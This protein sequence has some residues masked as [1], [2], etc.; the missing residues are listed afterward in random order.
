MSRLRSFGIAGFRSLKSVKVEEFGP[1]T[2]LIGPNGAGKSNLLSAMRL[3]PMLAS[4]SLGRYIL[5]R[6]GADA[7]LHYGLDTT[8][9]LAIAVEFDGPLRYEASL[10]FAAPDRLFFAHEACSDG[11]AGS[12]AG[13]PGFE[14][15]LGGSTAAVARRVVNE[16]RH[17]N[18][19]HFHDTSDRSALRTHAQL[20][21]AAYLKSEGSNLASYLWALRNGGDETLPAWNRILGWVRSI[22]PFIHDLVPDGPAAGAQ[23]MLLTWRD[24]RGK[25][26]GPDALSDGTLRAIALFTA[27]GQPATK[28]PW[29]IT[30]DE[31]ELGLHPAALSL[32]VEVMQS[33]PDTCQ[34]VVGTQSTAFLDAVEPEDVLVCDRV[35]GASEFRR[36]SRQELSVWL[37][38]EYSLARLYD[39]N[40][41][42]GRP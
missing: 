27:L 36:L 18:Y 38:D 30:I 14:S 4:G 25:V 10:E 21:D 6:G 22:A 3:I 11:G 16:F 20:A 42:G 15:S 8:K 17:W 28:L 23:S 37:D 24:E 26:F 9:A 31:P 32:L 12:F 33:V 40:V 7:N 1:L 5:R 2:V 39:M 35:D 19:F 34:I 41:L 29:L 13:D